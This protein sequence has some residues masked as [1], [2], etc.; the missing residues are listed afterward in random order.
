MPELRR[1]LELKGA[2]GLHLRRAALVAR[3]VTPL[4]ADITVALDGRRAN[5]KSVL[6]LLTLGAAPGV[7]L[8]V[9][10]EGRDAHQALHRVEQLLASEQDDLW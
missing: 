3:A 6:S 8:L 7:E 9:T 10:A 5:A 4:A 1:T 2:L